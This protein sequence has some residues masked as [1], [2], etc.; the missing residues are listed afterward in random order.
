MNRRG[1]FFFIPLAVGLFHFEVNANRFCDLSLSS[2]HKTNAGFPSDA[3]DRFISYFGALLDKRVIQEE[4][5][6]VF[7]SELEQGKIINPLQEKGGS[8]AE[9]HDPSVQGYIAYEVLDPVRLL[10]WARQRIKEQKRARV[11]RTETREKT[12]DPHQKIEFHPVQV[13]SFQMEGESG[14]RT[15]RLTHPIEVMS[16]PVTQKHWVDLMGEN[17]SRFVKGSHSIRMSRNGQSIRLQ[18]DHPVEGVTWWSTLVFANQLSEKNGLKPVYDL[19]GID[20]E[21]LTTA[22]SGTL[23]AY[24]GKPKI[25]TNG[26]L[27]ESEGYRLPTE[28]EQIFLLHAGGASQGK[29]HFGDDEEELKNYGWYFSNSDDKTHPVAGLKPLVLDGKCFYDLHGNVWE[30][31]WNRRK[32]ALKRN[33]IGPKGPFAIILHG[34]SAFG[35]SSELYSE[36]QH[37]REPN[38]RNCTIGFRL[39]RTLSKP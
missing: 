28:E 17:P 24:S 7:V 3:T 5:F 2:L 25:N 13:G 27:H 36:S 12:Q 37:L 26:G 34:G 19:S 14:K 35:L 22:E 10:K 38:F 31:S 39:V 29:Y 9:I 11:Q 20:W 15:V 4:E 16:T 30:W 6:F 33:P 23:K 8:S 32:R 1:P 21:E 18:P